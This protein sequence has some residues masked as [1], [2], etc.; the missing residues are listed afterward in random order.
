M[1][2]LTELITLTNTDINSNEKSYQL[3]VAI[4]LT[5]FN[6][7]C[8][9][10]DYIPALNEFPKTA[11]RKN[12]FYGARNSGVKLS[13]F[14]DKLFLQLL[15]NSQFT[16]EKIFLMANITNGYISEYIDSEDYKDGVENSGLY[17]LHDANHNQVR[18]LL[19]KYFEA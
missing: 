13:Y 3:D 9:D 8:G 7:L 12:I 16:P 19:N 1:R 2:N 10:I 17:K 14:E 5:Q 4:T 6:E 15:P 18:E 11:F